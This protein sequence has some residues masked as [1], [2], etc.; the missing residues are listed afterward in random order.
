MD[1]FLGTEAAATVCGIPGRRNDEGTRIRSYDLACGSLSASSVML[2]GAQT[3]HGVASRSAA[4]RLNLV[5]AISSSVERDGDAESASIVR[6]GQ[7][8]LLRRRLKRAAI[9]YSNEWG[10]EEWSLMAFEIAWC[11]SKH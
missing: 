5:G 11:R 1:R 2:A 7:R 10:E 4:R 6:A 8:D 3:C 9:L